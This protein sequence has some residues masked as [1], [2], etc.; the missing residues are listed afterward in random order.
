VIAGAT[1]VGKSELAVEVAERCGGEIVGADAFQ[2]YAGL[3]VLTAKPSPALRA[4]VPHHLIGEVPLAETFNVGRYMELAA[5]RMAE[6]RARGKVPVIVGGTG[7]Y[8][9]ALTCGLA[10][11]P[12]ADAGLR[13]KLEAAT[14][15][16]LQARLATLD[17]EAMRWIDTQN[18][19]RLVRAIEVS[20][21]SGKPFSSFRA[22]WMEEG[23]TGSLGVVLV[24]ERA[25]LNTRIDRRVEAMFTE[26]VVEEVARAGDVGPTAGQTLGLRE[27]R[28]FLNGEMD[29]AACR[30]AIQQAT[31]KYAKRQATWFRKE[32]GLVEMGVTEG[33]VRRIVGLVAERGV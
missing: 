3:D 18:R 28:A 25:E 16:E 29:L 19:R 31:R 17:P 27:I 21:L 20:I 8:V 22:E 23:P 10:E 7:L 13:A 32:R 5:A 24:R 15:E 1:G 12:T 9:R 26:G 2:V 33:V 11:L 14:T 6:I 30:A 4:R